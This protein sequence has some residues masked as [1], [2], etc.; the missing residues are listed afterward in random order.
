MNRKALGALT[1]TF[2][3]IGFSM[4]LGLFFMS[5]GK[6]YI[7]ERA[8]FVVGV[9]GGKAGCVDIGIDIVKVGGRPEVCYSGR[10]LRILVENVGN[11][12]I[13]QFQARMVDAAGV[14]TVDDTLSEALPIGDSVMVDVPISPPGKQAK[15]TPQIIIEGKREFCFDKALT[16]DGPFRPC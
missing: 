16:T 11:T 13:Q 2:V 14:K 6:G 4:V 12:V 9:A 15:I 8:E 10:N 7:E 5:W 1:C 3:L